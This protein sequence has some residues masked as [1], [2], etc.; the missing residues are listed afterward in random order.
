MISFFSLPLCL[1]LNSLARLRNHFYHDHNH[2]HTSVRV[3]DNQTGDDE[4]E[5]LLQQIA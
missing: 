4:T 5:E 3:Q 1:F 2:M